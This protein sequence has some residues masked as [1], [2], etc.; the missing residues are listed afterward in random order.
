MSERLVPAAKYLTYTEAIGLYNA[1][2]QVGVVALVKTCGPPSLPF[3]DGLYYQL[4]LQQKDLEA[5]H[6]V[7][8]EFS[9]KQAQISVEAQTCPRCGSVYVWPDSHLPWWKKVIYAGTTVYKCQDCGHSF[10]A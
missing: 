8:E 9:Q 5:A 7:L 4:Q 2:T 6:P 1:L 3:G 10:F